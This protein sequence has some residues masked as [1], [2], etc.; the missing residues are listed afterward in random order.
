MRAQES[1]GQPFLG[2]ADLRPHSFVFSKQNDSVH[3]NLLLIFVV[4]S[5]VFQSTVTRSIHVIPTEN[6]NKRTKKK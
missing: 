3:L 6:T 4:L 2:F 5:D 1:V